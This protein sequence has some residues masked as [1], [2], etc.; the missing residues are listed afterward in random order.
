MVKEG[1]GC[2]PRGR[3]GASGFK[4][5][6]GNGKPRAFRSV[7]RPS[8]LFRSRG[9]LR[10]HAHK[11]LPSRESRRDRSR[12]RLRRRVS[13]R[14]IQPGRQPLLG[15]RSS[16]L[17]RR[18]RRDRNVSRERRLLHRE[19][20]EGRASIPGR[21]NTRG[22]SSFLKCAGRAKRRRR[23]GGKHSVAAIQ[24]GVALR[25]PPHSKSEG[26][27][28]KARNDNSRLVRALGS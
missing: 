15:L 22:A 17:N 27:L 11:R 26:S 5:G 7:L 14:E 6:Q 18:V 8:A 25:L 9:G 13:E 20:V 23:F 28:L 16:E 10:L 12:D 2:S 4:Q 24:S 21:S 3:G 19:K 1:G